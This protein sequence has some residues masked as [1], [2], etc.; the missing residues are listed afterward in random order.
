MAG[1]IRWR[2]VRPLAFVAGALGALLVVSG[3]AWAAAPGGT[4]SPAVPPGP[5]APQP[6]TVQW[7]QNHRA[8]TV[9]ADQEGTRA[10]APA[11]QWTH[12]QI[13]G[14]QEQLRVP[15]F[16][17]R[18]GAKGWI[19][20]LAVGPSGAPPAAAEATSASAAPATASASRPPAGTPPRGDPTPPRA[21]PTPPR[22]EPTPATNPRTGDPPV[23][24]RPVAIPT[25]AALRPAGA[26]APAAPFEPGGERWVQSHNA[27][28]LWADR[29]GDAS[30]A[31][32]PQ[33]TFLRWTGPQ[34][35][36]RI[37]VQDPRS[38]ATGWVE[39]RTVGPSGPPPASAPA[40]PTPPADA[41][42]A[43]PSEAAAA[44]AARSVERPA[45][46]GPGERWIDVD[47]TQQRLRLIEDDRVVHTAP[48]TTGKAGFATPTGTFR[49]FQRV[50][51]DTMDSETTGIAHGS[52]EGYLLTD[53]R[54]SQYFAHGGFALHA[55]YWQPDGVFGRAATSHGCVGMRLA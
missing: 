37:P 5:G 23:S 21:E 41:A 16:D 20:A 32:L 33:W 12:F 46:V 42:P 44:L 51:N 30:V 11:P 13:A 26:P 27:T 47:L 25:P 35:G 24:I 9:W 19:D 15:V 48:V 1:R 43:R 22:A 6:T 14:P 53:V 4:T 36:L 54:Y 3:T 31:P 39:A 45:S 49:I 2:Y 29:E 50:A 7:I 8:T 55:N 34:S 28:T 18:T 38:G 17:P 52:G 10:L 40:A